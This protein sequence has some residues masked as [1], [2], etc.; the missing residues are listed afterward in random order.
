MN[1]S[2]K[3]EIVKALNIIEDSIHNYKGLDAGIYMLIL[4]SKLKELLKQIYSVC[5]MESKIKELYE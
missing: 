3:E 4:E 1:K 2:A 5:K